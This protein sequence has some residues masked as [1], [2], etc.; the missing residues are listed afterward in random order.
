MAAIPFL[1]G[2]AGMLVN[3]YVTDWLVKG[4]MAPIKSRKICIIAGMFCSAAFT[5]VVPQATTSMTAVLL[6]GM[7]LFCIHFAGTSCW[8][9][10][11]VAVASRM[12]RR[13]AVSRTLPASSAPLLRRSLLVLLLIPPT[14]SVWH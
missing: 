14:H 4:G 5:L 7:A 6:I 1:F 11:H 3:G 13:W 2:A 10:I 9:L 8:G 12:T